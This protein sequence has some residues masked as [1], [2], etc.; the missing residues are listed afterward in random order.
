[1]NKRL[2]FVNEEF[3]FQVLYAKK[4]GGTDLTEFEVGFINNRY[5]A[6]HK[7]KHRCT[8]T[9]K[10]MRIMK[11]IYDKV[12]AGAKIKGRFDSELHVYRQSFTV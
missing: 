3:I 12:E 10:Q 2:E 6:V 1:M 4:H 11:E 5:D 9:H 7:Y 8:N